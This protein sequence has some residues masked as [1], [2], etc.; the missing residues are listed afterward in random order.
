VISAT[1]IPPTPQVGL[2]AQQNELRPTLSGSC[3]C[4]PGYAVIGY[5]GY[6][7]DII[8]RFRLI[9]AQINSNGSPG[10]TIAYSCP[11]GK[12]STGNPLDYG[13]SFSAPAGSWMVGFRIGDTPY[14]NRT[15]TLN[16]IRGYSQTYTEVINLS[17]NSVLNGELKGCCPPANR[18]SDQYAPAGHVLVGMNY[19]IDGGEA[20]PF[21]N[22]VQFKYAPLATTQVLA[23]VPIT[24]NCG[25][26]LSIGLMGNRTYTCADINTTPSLEIS[27]MDENFNRSSTC[28]INLPVINKFTKEIY[29]GAGATQLAGTQFW[30]QWQ[31]F[32]ISNPMNDLD[33]MKVDISWPLYDSRPSVTVRLY[34]GIG[35]GGAL[36]E[37]VNLP[38]GFGEFVNEITRQE[39]IPFIQNISL[40]VGNYT[41]RITSDDA[42]KNYN[43]L[44][45][46]FQSGDLTSA[47]EFQNG[48]WT[49][50]ITAYGNSSCPVN[51]APEVIVENRIVTSKTDVGN[52]MITMYPNPAQ[53]DLTFLLKGIDQQ[54][55]LNIFDIQG[56][57]VSDRMIDAGT[58]RLVLDV[59]GNEFTNGIYMILIEKAGER[60][61][62]KLVIS[63]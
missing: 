51:F 27:V 60:K 4:P 6:Q 44:S 24:E 20:G 1:S 63:R 16:S 2:L 49:K 7:G 45:R 32:N 15:G 58:E 18:T 35:T 30:D 53:N 61:Y 10:N 17:S 42:G 56:K 37:Q 3:D 29:T 23:T 31:A 46:N 22:T 13:T 12:P 48:P 55:K 62:E 33:S 40:P 14:W 21:S 52:F 11:N 19:Y 39:I 26:N 57:K 41:L 54:A 28:M 5:E 34:A 9:C 25:G 36:I 47:P 59:S 50:L 38:S 8:D 43:W